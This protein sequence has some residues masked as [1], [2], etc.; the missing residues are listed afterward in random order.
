MGKERMIPGDWRG[1][2]EG[3]TVLVEAE[4]PW[5]AVMVI[6]NRHYICM[7]LL[8]CVRILGIFRTNTNTTGI[9]YTNIYMVKEMI[10]E[11]RRRTPAL[12]DAYATL[13]GLRI[14]Y[15]RI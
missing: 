6:D 8:L 4:S 14:A 13:R 12:L 3:G 10:R 15:G 5:R 7:C 11:S 1:C 2:R 9:L